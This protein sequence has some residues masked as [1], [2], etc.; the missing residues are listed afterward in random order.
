MKHLISILVFTAF[1]STY[2]VYSQEAGEERIIKIM[3]LGNSI[4]QGRGA[5]NQASYRRHLWVMLKKAGYENIEFVGSM[6]NVYGNDADYFKDYDTRHESHWNWS[7]TDILHG[8]KEG[9]RGAYN[10]EYDFGSG[11]TGGKLSMWLKDFNP[12]IVLMHVGSNDVFRTDATIP[13]KEFKAT[14][15][16]AI[17]DTLKQIIA[18]IRKHNPQVTILWAGIIP[19]EFSSIAKQRIVALNEIIEMEASLLDSYRSRV[20]YVDQHTGFDARK[21]RDTYDNTHPN[22]KGARKMAVKWFELLSRYMDGKTP[23]YQGAGFEIRIRKESPLIHGREF[24]LAIINARDPR[25]DQYLDEIHKVTVITNLTDANVQK[26][27]GPVKFAKGEGVFYLSLTPGQHILEVI[28][29]SFPIKGLSDVIDVI[30]DETSIPRAKEYHGTIGI[31]GATKPFNSASGNA[32]RD[33]T[34]DLSEDFKIYVHQ[35]QLIIN[36][37]GMINKAILYNTL[38]R[39]EKV[40]YLHH[41]PESIFAL[42]NLIP[43]I[44]ILSLMGDGYGYA[45]KILIE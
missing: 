31:N 21:D 3:P 41:S 12:D 7:A 24:P 20:F 38:G 35:K 29:D 39:V 9:R 18:V 16:H 23:P 17:V 10:S 5:E 11:Y 6:N 44:Y 15:R 33:E 22:L 13:L 25:T 8:T 36:S 30:Q 34:V 32:A 2:T 26:F 1:I 42:D 19:S 4:T 40:F 27:H 28:I 45:K 14:Y 37:P 43:G